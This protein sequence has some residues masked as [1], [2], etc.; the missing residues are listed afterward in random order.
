MFG[1]WIS[2]ME[3]IWKSKSMLILYLIFI[4]LLAANVWGGVLNGSGSLRF[5]AG[6]I[7]LNNLNMPWFMM[8][9]ISLVLTLVVLPVIY[10]NQL[11]GEIHSGAYR[12]YVLRPFTR[13]QIWFSK[14]LALAST[15]VILIAFTFIF[16]MAAAWL[17]FPQADAMTLYGSNASVNVT[18]AI[19]YSFNFFGLF[20]LACLAKLMFCSVICLFISRPLVSFVAIFVL[21]LLIYRIAIDLVILSDPFQKILL[22]LRPEGYSPFWIYSLGTLIICGLISFVKWQRKMV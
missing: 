22:A 2:E 20:T 13:F 15:T 19:L 8:D 21:S 5:G 6:R 18:R 17:L 3:R 1:V 14:L 11:S 7:E 4:L 12:L 9:G 16:S 10:V